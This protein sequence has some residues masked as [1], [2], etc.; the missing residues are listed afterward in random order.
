M[1]TLFF[2]VLVSLVPISETDPRNKMA[3]Q[4]VTL[5]SFIADQESM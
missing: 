4:R 5:G 2:T 1:Y 3:E